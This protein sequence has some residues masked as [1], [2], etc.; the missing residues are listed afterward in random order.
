MKQRESLKNMKIRQT[1][2]KNVM[3]AIE[4][5]RGESPETIFEFEV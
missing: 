1:H 4:I 5:L 2:K 3:S